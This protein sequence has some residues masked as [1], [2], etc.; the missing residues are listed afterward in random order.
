[1]VITEFQL[2]RIYYEFIFLWWKNFLRCLVFWFGALE[3]FFFT[4]LVEG[5]KLFYEDSLSVNITRV[6]P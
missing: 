4:L 5:N 6:A 3:Q 1:M 2:W